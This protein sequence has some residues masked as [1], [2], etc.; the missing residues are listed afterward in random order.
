M[1]IHKYG[2][3]KHW[4]NLLSQ[5]IKEKPECIWQRFLRIY[6]FI[7]LLTLF[8]N[9]FNLFI[10]SIQNKNIEWCSVCLCVCLFICLSVCLLYVP[11][12]SSQDVVFVLRHGVW[13]HPVELQSSDGDYLVLGQV[14]EL[15]KQNRQTS[16]QC[17]VR[18]CFGIEAFFDS[19]TEQLKN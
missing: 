18:K 7:S 10:K 1:S 14:K 17:F 3:N 11:W 8:L 13:W 9:S 2:R 16:V 4:K 19:R 12:S 15:P 6:I 5:Q